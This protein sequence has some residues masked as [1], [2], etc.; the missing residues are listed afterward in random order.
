[1]KIDIPTKDMV[2]RMVEEA[3]RKD[4]N[5]VHKLLDRFRKRLIEVERKVKNKTD[6]IKGINRNEK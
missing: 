1:M 6:K 5:K 3:V 2:K 4:M